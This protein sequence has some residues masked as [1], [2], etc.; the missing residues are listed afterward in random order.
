MR[1]QE[2]VNNRIAVLEIKGQGISEQE[3]Q[4]LTDQMRSE[5]FSTWAATP[6]EEVR[7]NTVLQDLGLGETGCSAPECALEAGGLLGASY[8]VIGSVSKAGQTYE[9]D[10]QMFDVK[11][12]SLYKS[13]NRTYHGEAGDE[14][15]VMAVQRL[16]W[17]MMD[18]SPP[19][20]RFPPDDR[21]LP[22]TLEPTADVTVDTS[23]TVRTKA[24]VAKNYRS[25]LIGAVVGGTV[26]WVL[27]DEK[28]HHIIQPPKF[29]P[30]P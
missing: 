1:G 28:E 29:P 13:V 8:V 26:A 25:V 9:L 14:G 24:W 22:L 11:A 30:V 5:L 2:G 10:F 18:L 19:P 16:V 17:D 4:S 21:P 20:G 3:A 15:L 27:T 6:V 7:I 12:V 23:L